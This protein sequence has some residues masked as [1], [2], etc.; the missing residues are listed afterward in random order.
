MD[1]KRIYIKDLMTGELSPASADDLMKLGYESSISLPPLDKKLPCKGF[2]EVGFDFDSDRWS[3][4]KVIL[5]K[6][7]RNFLN[8]EYP[9]RQATDSWNSNNPLNH[10]S[11]TPSQ[12]ERFGLRHIK[13][14][15]E[16]N[17]KIVVPIE[18]YRLLYSHMEST[19]KRG[20]KLSLMGEWEYRFI[21]KESN[22][23]LLQRA[24][25]EIMQNLL[26]ID[27]LISDYLYHI[28]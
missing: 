7:I 22:L 24:R 15:V 9:Y 16:G 17:L 12:T 19:K 10:Y 11:Q 13:N 6:E 5:I 14:F 4:K 2:V 1:L 27:A 23:D 18:I 28:P 8:E 3:E 25:E 21:E 20:V 26:K